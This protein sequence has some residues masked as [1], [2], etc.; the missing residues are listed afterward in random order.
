MQFI[1]TDFPNEEEYIKFLWNF[2][3]PTPEYKRMS[4]YDSFN[5]L[6]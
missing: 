4:G 5:E 2:T 6:E 3:N 1:Y